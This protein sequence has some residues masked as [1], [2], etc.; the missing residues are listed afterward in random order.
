M[1]PLLSDLT[2]ITVICG[3]GVG[4]LAVILRYAWRRRKDVEEL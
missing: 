1:S 2:T 4:V 3:V